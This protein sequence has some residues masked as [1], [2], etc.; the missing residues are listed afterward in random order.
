MK[1]YYGNIILTYQKSLEEKSKA[2]LFLTMITSVFVAGFKRAA[3]TFIPTV[4]G[5][6]LGNSIFELIKDEV[7]AV[8]EEYKFRKEEKGG[9]VCILENP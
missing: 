6:T 9:S 8:I 1:N 4:L 2:N 5:T 3:A 7:Q